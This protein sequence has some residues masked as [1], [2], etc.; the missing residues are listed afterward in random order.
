MQTS[1]RVQL[2]VKEGKDL[3]EELIRDGLSIDKDS[4]GYPNLGHEGAHSSRR[5]VHAGGDQTGKVLHQFLLEKVSHK[6]TLLPYRLAVE[7]VIADERCIGVVVFHPS[8]QKETIYAK[9]IVLAVDWA[10]YSSF[11]FFRC[12]RRWT[13]TCLSSRSSS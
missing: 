12:N 8:G 5:I 10:L 6:I 9:H 3:V 13:F 11:Q 4:K 7:L 1:H 2:L